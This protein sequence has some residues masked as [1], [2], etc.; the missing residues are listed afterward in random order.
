MSGVDT[1]HPRQDL[2][3]QFDATSIPEA[4]TRTSRVHSTPA[5]GPATAHMNARGAAAQANPPCAPTATVIHGAGGHVRIGRSRRRAR[6]RHPDRAAAGPVGDEPFEDPRVGPCREKQARGQ[7][8]P[9]PPR[10]AGPAAVLGRPHRSGRCGRWLRPASSS[11]MS[12]SP[13]VSDVA[14]SGHYRVTLQVLTDFRPRAVLASAYVSHDSGA[15][16]R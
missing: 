3:S 16:C 1:R 14:P 10:P 4:P 6:K 12:R 5:S 13:D 2:E 15:G 11:T 9:P 7:R 8:E